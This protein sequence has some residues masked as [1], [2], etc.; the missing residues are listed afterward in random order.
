MK[1]DLKSLTFEEL[2]MLVLES[3]GKKFHAKYIFSFIHEKHVN[4][5]SLITPI[6]AALRDVLIADGA[7]ISSLKLITEESDPDGTKKYLFETAAGK[8][9]ETALLSDDGRQTICLSS[10]V[11]CKMGC[12]F[13]ATARIGFSADLTAGEILEQFY[14]VTELDGK[15]SN[16]VFMGMGEPFDNYDNVIKA[17]MLLNHPDGANMGARHITISTCGLPD[18]IDKFAQLEQQFRLAISLHSPKDAAR[19][20]LMPVA[21]R[22]GIKSLFESVKNYYKK[23][24]RRITIEYCMMDGV[25]DSIADAAALARLLK[26]VKCNVNLIEFNSYPGSDFEASSTEAIKAFAEHLE[27]AGIETHIRFRRGRAIKA[28]CGQLGAGWAKRE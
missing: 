9:F 24:G 14:A 28:A 6:S 25:N 22:H 23:T 21:A 4:D 20:A 7:F 27:K 15:I 16:V 5:I 2:T 10:Q 8:R 18:K 12:E 26:A 17:A 1:T 13:C 3:G 19:A 11:G